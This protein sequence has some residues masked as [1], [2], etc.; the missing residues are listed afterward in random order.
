MCD[1]GHVAACRELLKP[2]R[3]LSAGTGFGLS[4]IAEQ[5]ATAF[6]GDR[7]HDIWAGAHGLH[8]AIALGNGFGDD[9]KFIWL[10][11]GARYGSTVRR[12]MRLEA[13]C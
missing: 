6:V 12:F 8:Q 7:L 11:K 5:K 1:R 3:A 10:C 2:P 9:S 4:T 13:V